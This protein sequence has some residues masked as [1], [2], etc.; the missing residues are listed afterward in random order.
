M[1]G[2]MRRIEAFPPIRG[3]AHATG[4]VNV[5]RNPKVFSHFFFGT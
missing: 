2:L 1:S 3:A 5:G 4:F